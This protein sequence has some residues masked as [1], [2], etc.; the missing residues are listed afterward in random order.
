MVRTLKD[1]LAENGLSPDE[2][3]GVVCPCGRVTNS[4][5]CVDLTPL[6][7]EYRQALGLD[8]A[9]FICGA[10]QTR[11]FRERHVSEDEFYALLG[12]DDIGVLFTHNERDSEWEGG[13]NRRHE[14]Q[15]PRHE[16]VT[17]ARAQAAMFAAVNETGSGSAPASAPIPL[18]YRVVKQEMVIE[19]ILADVQRAATAERADPEVE[20]DPL[21]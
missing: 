14:V 17:R 16:K 19:R 7:M 4:D 6:P 1:V 20:V 10:C 3:P 12:Q 18:R 13:C 8:Q 2:N 5:C 11:L 15:R 9:D 21:A